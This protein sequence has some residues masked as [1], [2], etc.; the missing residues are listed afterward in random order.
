LI[1]AGGYR[2]S[3]A[4]LPDSAAAGW[5]VE[6]LAKGWWW[7][8]LAATGKAV[9]S[10]RAWEGESASLKL[11]HVLHELKSHFENHGP[12][13][14]SLN[15]GSII[16]GEGI[17]NRV[18]D[19]MLAKVEIR[20]I[21]KTSYPKAEKLISSLCTAYGLTWETFK[22]V[23]P[24]RPILDGPLATAYMHSVEKITGK[25][26]QGKVSLGGSDALY[27]TQ[28]GIP[29]IISCPEGGG[30]HSLNEWV[31][32]KSLEQFVPILHDFLDAVARKPY[33]N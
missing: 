2:P 31:D 10:G 9:H 7:V 30:H 12:L 26:P 21:D 6:K 27:Y 28:R 11:I 22:H 14:D 19:H 23:E 25:Q 18:P 13:T 8:E 32:K 20:L 5:N 3:I 15:V 33:P 16:G 1:E 29:C 4:I 17:Y 24:A